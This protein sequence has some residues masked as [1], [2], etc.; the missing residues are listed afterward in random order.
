MSYICTVDGIIIA[1]GQENDYRHNKCPSL[2]L[3]ILI[4]V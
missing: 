1:L 3:V 4:H 2:H